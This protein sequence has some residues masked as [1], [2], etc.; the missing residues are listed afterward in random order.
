MLV[1]LREDQDLKRLIDRSR[2]APVL[3]FKHSTQCP[4][5]SQAHTQ[6]ERFANQSADVTCGMV[7]VIENRALSN[8]IAE[9]FGITHESPQV[10]VVRNAEP[11]WHA[12][13]W[14]ITTDSLSEA[15]KDH[16]QSS[17]P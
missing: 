11:V 2:L 3:I 10:I 17:R 5:S 1:L 7:L 15:L 16:A 4:I 14:T 6:V 8:A 13:H 12:S 9:Q